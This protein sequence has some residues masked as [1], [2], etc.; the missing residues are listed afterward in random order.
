VRLAALL[1]GFAVAV[2]LRVVVGGDDVARSVP[3]G[4]VFAAALL[5]LSAAA[6][7]RVPV[8]RR[9]LALGLLGIVVV[10]L[11]VG[12]EQLV[13]VRPLRGT[14]GLLPWAAAVTVVASAEEVFLRG[15][16]HDAVAARWPVPFAVGV[17][18]VCFALLHV[19]LY[20][21]HVVPLDLAV[22]VVLGGLRAEAGTPFAPAVTHVGA[23][24]VGWFLR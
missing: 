16:L 17:G 4:L 2:G 23:D 8:T 13:T 22:G 5:V 20:G 12:L 7:T 14:T 9:A 19:P 1:V 24:L 21:W 18:A 10:C 11:P 15:A 3:A 6:R